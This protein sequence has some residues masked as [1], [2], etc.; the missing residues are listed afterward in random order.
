MA[1]TDKNLNFHE[2]FSP[3]LKYISKILELAQEDYNGKI[4]EISKCTGIPSGAHSG[5]VK[6]SII[7]AKYMGLVEYEVKNTVYKIVSTDLGKLIYKED[8]YLMERVTKSIL[9]YNITDEKIGAPQWC[10]LFRKYKGRAVT[11]KGKFKKELEEFFNKSNVRLATIINSY[12]DTFSDLN[13]LDCTD[14]NIKFNICSVALENIY[15]YGYTLLK[16]W[17]DLYPERKEIT[18]TEVLDEIKW[19]EPFG[20]DY[21]RVMEALELMEEY[22]ILKINRLLSPLTIIKLKNSDELKYDLYSMLI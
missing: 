1:I 4:E 8:P 9:N 14:K 13:I 3:D 7:Y 22:N 19:G 17:E 10:Y 21:E 2:T 16:T 5:K 20:F 6:P 12:T 11:D 15:V 18:L